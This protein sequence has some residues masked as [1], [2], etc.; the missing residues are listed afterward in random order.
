MGEGEGRLS[1]GTKPGQRWQ[2]RRQ[3]RDTWQ[4]NCWGPGRATHAVGAEELPRNEAEMAEA[5][6]K[7][8]LWLC[9]GF[10][11]GKSQEGTPG[12]TGA[13]SVGAR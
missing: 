6:T 5:D 11:A 13:I 3:L 10:Q 8:S 4:S 1:Q 9:T 12:L 2:P 7:R